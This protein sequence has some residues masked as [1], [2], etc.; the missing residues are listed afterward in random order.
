[1]NL[2]PGQE[3]G[4]TAAWVRTMTLE[5]TPIDQRYRRLGAREYRYTSAT[6]FSTL[7]ETDEFG[8]VK[9]YGR[10]WESVG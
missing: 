2:R 1:M 5:V 10:F 7:L 4:V 8:L 6:G 9:R 3:A